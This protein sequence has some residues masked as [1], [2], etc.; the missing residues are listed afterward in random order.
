SPDRYDALLATSGL[1]EA[2]ESDEAASVIIATGT[3]GGRTTTGEDLGRQRK[4]LF[5]AIVGGVAACLGFAGLILLRRGRRRPG[6]DLEGPASTGGA[7][8]ER[9]GAG[10]DE[11]P[12]STGAPLAAGAAQV[13]PAP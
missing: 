8:G 12:A 10:A 13:R 9:G 1:N 7:P 11:A 3:I 6:G 5:V 2:G 4:N